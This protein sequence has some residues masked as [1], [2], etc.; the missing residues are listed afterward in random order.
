MPWRASFLFFLERKNQRTFK[1]RYQPG[2]RKEGS[3]APQILERGCFCAGQ[4]TKELL[5]RVISSVE[6][7]KASPRRRFLEEG[8]FCAGQRII[9]LSGSKSAKT[10][11]YLSG[12]GEWST[13]GGIAL[14]VLG[15]RLRQ[16]H[17]FCSSGTYPAAWKRWGDKSKIPAPGAA[18]AIESPLVSAAG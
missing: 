6:R 14:P 18:A 13:F 9:S 2:G 1:S 7:K 5:N 4:R 15:C 10:R 3:S 11:L 17:S 8:Y 12:Y 16:S